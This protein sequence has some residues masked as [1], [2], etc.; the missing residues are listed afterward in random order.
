MNSEVLPRFA[1]KALYHVSHV[2]K[3]FCFSY[4][5]DRVSWFLV[6]WGLFFA[7]ASLDGDPLT[8]LEWQAFAAMSSLLVEMGSC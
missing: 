4:I 1:R 3:P 7:W 8:Q 2:P 5:E 6:F